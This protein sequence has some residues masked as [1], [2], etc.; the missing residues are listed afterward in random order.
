MST[1]QDFNLKKGETF[2]YRI[3]IR[4]DDGNYLNLLGYDLTGYC[5]YT[6]CNTGY[7]LNLNPSIYSS[8]SGAIDIIIPYTGTTG[9]PVTRAP[10][11][12]NGYKNGNSE[13]LLN[14]YI[15]IHPNPINTIY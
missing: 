15:Y 10:Y 12:L 6:Y 7:L 4:D 8:V 13:E 3:V 9:L 1:R 11:A 2:N 5:K 14:G